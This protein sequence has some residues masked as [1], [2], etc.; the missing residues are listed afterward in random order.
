MARVRS[1]NRDKAFEIYKEHD[2]NIDLV[3][4]ANILDISSGTVR[5]W[6]NKDAWEDKLNGTLHKKQRNVSKENNNRKI[7]KKARKNIVVDEVEELLD[8]TELTE[9]QRL[10]CIYYIKCFNATKAYQKAYGCDYITANTNGSRLLVNAS[11][12]NE[13]EK[14]K[15]DKLNSVM[16]S[17]DDIF[18]RYIDIAFS[19]ITDYLDFG[20]EEVEGEFGPYTRSY[21]SLKN[22]FEVDGTLISEVSQGKDGIKLKLQDKMKALQW[23][24]DRMDLLPTNTR[25]R[26]ENEK[27][28]LE[29]DV[30]KLELEIMKQGGQDEEFEDDGFMEALEAQ[31]GDTW[32]D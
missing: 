18:Q 16:L 3:E 21:V 9:K 31:V 25:I 5:G 26:L 8:N 1:P 12:K 7:D 30:M 15:R 32:D 22:S 20:N 11:I 13:I 14:L 10:F 23:L 19:D 4:I 28:K 29:L 6:K 2:G 17:E 27:S 24:S